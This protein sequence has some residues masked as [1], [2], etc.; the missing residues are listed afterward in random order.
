MAEAAPHVVICPNSAPGHYTPFLRFAKRLS[1]E[2]VIV[3]LVSSDRNIQ[4]LKLLL[5]SSTRGLRFLGLLDKQAHLS[6]F[7]WRAP[8]TDGTPESLRVV[9]LLRD[10]VTEISSPESLQLR[11]VPPAGSP[12]CIIYD[13]F[14]VWAQTD[15]KQLG[16]ECH[17]L[18]VSP[19][20]SLSCSLEVSSR[21]K[22]I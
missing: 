1:G 7:E 17:L 5:G 4:E 18:W 13:T 12:V 21:A 19:A 2:G 20:C 22:I 8:L 9:E 16:I 15:A 3:T 6:N 14:N 11:G 10:L